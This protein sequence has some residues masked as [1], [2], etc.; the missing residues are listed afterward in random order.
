[1]SLNPLLNSFRFELGCYVPFMVNF[2]VVFM[3]N[4]A[5]L[6][7]MLVSCFYGGIRN[8]IEAGVRVC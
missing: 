6:S 8:D 4:V 7:A 1:M 3:V 2:D 5:N